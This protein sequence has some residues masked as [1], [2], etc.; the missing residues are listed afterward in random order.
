MVSKT[1]NEYLLTLLRI[2]ELW[3]DMS[4]KILIGI[5]IV[6]GI[7]IVIGIKIGM[8]VDRWV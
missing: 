1:M 8:D 7:Q 6:I 3:Y 2:Y 4:V 5:K